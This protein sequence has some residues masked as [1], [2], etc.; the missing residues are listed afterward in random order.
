MAGIHYISIPTIDN[1]NLPNEI[2]DKCYK[3]YERYGKYKIYDILNE[4][5]N[6]SRYSYAIRNKFKNINLIKRY[7]YLYRQAMVQT[8]SFVYN[9]EEFELIDPD[10]YAGDN[11]VCPKCGKELKV[12]PQRGSETYYPL[13]HYRDIQEIVDK[14]VTYKRFPVK[15]TLYITFDEFVSSKEAA[16][17]TDF[18]FMYWSVNKDGTP[19][20]IS[21]I[22]TRYLNEDGDL[23]LYAC[24]ASSATISETS[25]TLVSTKIVKIVRYNFRVYFRDF[26]NCKTEK[27]TKTG[28]VFSNWTLDDGSE[29]PVDLTEEQLDM[30][31]TE[32][33]NVDGYVDVVDIFT[34]DPE[35]SDYILEY[36]A[37]IRDFEKLFKVEE[38]E[39]Y[40][41]KGF[42]YNQY[43]KSMGGIEVHDLEVVASQTK[44][45]S[46]IVYEMTQD[47]SLIPWR[48]LDR[49]KYKFSHYTLN[50]DGSEMTPSQE[51]TSIAAGTHLQMYAVFKDIYDEDCKVLDMQNMY[52]DIWGENKVILYAQYS[53]DI[54]E[55][56]Y[57]YDDSVY[58]CQKSNFIYR[59]ETSLTSPEDRTS[60]QT[61]IN[62]YLTE[63]YGNEVTYPTMKNETFHGWSL[64]N[65]GE[66][67]TNFGVKYNE[68]ET[69]TLY[70][71]FNHANKHWGIDRFNR[72]TKNCYCP[73]CRKRN[74]YLGRYSEA[75]HDYVKD[76]YL[77][78]L[79]YTYFN[80]ELG[81]HKRYVNGNNE[82]TYGTIPEI[83]SVSTLEDLNKSS[84]I[85]NG[86]TCVD[87]SRYA[88][89][90]NSSYKIY[91]YD[92]SRD[93]NYNPN[94]III[95]DDEPDMLDKKWIYLPRDRIVLTP[96]D[97]TG[98]GKL[99]YILSGF[100]K[101]Y[102]KQDGEII[103]VSEKNNKPLEITLQALAN[104]F[105]VNSSVEVVIGKNSDNTAYS[106]KYSV[107]LS[108][109]SINN[110][111][112]YNDEE[113]D[114]FSFTVE[115]PLVFTPTTSTFEGLYPNNVTTWK[116]S[117]IVG[118]YIV[119]GGYP[120][121]ESA[122]NILNIDPNSKIIDENGEEHIVTYYDT[123]RYKLSPIVEVG[124][125]R[126]T[127]TP[128]GRSLQAGGN[129]VANYTTLNSGETVDNNSYYVDADGNVITDLSAY[130]G[131]NY[132]GWH[133]IR[134]D[135]TKHYSIQDG[136]EYWLV[137]PNN[138][139]VTLRE[140]INTEEE[141]PITINGQRYNFTCYSIDGYAPITDKILDSTTILAKGKYKIHKVYTSTAIVV[142][143]GIVESSLF[144]TKIDDI[145]KG[146][147][148]RIL[149]IA[150]FNSTG[151][152]IRYCDNDTC[153]S[154]FRDIYQRKWSFHN[155]NA[156]VKNTATGMSTSNFSLDD[157]DFTPT[158][159]K[160]KS[161]LWRYPQTNQNKSVMFHRGG[162]GDIDKY[163]FDFEYKYATDEYNA[164]K[165]A[166]PSLSSSNNEYKSYVLKNLLKRIKG[167]DIVP[168]QDRPLKLYQ[169]Q[170]KEKLFQRF[171]EIYALMIEYT[172][173]HLLNKDEVE[174]MNDILQ[175]LPYDFRLG[176][177]SFLNTWDHYIK[178]SVSE[179]ADEN[180]ETYVDRIK[181]NFSVFFESN[182]LVVKNTI[183]YKKALF[184]EKVL[185]PLFNSLRNV[186][187][188][189]ES[190]Y[191]AHPVSVPVSK[192]HFGTITET[193]SMESVYNY[194]VENY[195]P[196]RLADLSPEKYVFIRWSLTEDGEP[197][198]YSDLNQFVRIG[199]DD[200]PTQVQFYAYFKE[201]YVDIV[202]ERNI[203]E[204]WFKDKDTFLNLYYSDEDL[205]SETHTLFSDIAK[206][207][208][209]GVDKTWWSRTYNNS[210]E[211]TYTIDD[212]IAS[213]TDV[214]FVNQFKDLV[215][216]VSE[217]IE[218]ETGVT[219]NM[220]LD[221][222]LASLENR[223]DNTD[224]D[225]LVFSHWS[226]D[227]YSTIP[228]EVRTDIKRIYSSYTT[229]KIYKVS[230]LRH[231]VD[232]STFSKDWFNGKEYTLAYIKDSLANYHEKLCMPMTFVSYMFGIMIWP[233]RI[234]AMTDSNGEIGSYVL[235][236]DT[237]VTSN[238]ID[239]KT[240]M[241]RKSSNGNS[242]L[243][244]K[245]SVVSKRFPAI[246]DTY[247]GNKIYEQYYIVSES[248]GTSFKVYSFM[249]NA[250]VD[251]Y[252][253][254]SDAYDYCLLLKNTSNP[255]L[256]YNPSRLVDIIAYSSN[257]D[258]S[259]LCII[260]DTCIVLFNC[261]TN[262]WITSFPPSSLFTKPN[263]FI[264][265]CTYN[266]EK[267]VIYLLSSQNEIATFDLNDESI[268][269]S[270]RTPNRDYD[271]VHIFF[272]PS[273]V[274]LT[275]SNIDTNVP[276]DINLLAA[277]VVNDESEETD[278]SAILVKQIANIEPYILPENEK[279]WILKSEYSETP[280]LPRGI[281]DKYYEE[282]SI[283]NQE[284]Y[285][286]NE[287]LTLRYSYEMLG[288]I[289]PEQTIEFS[290]NN[291]IYKRLSF[292]NNGISITDYQLNKR[293]LNSIGIYAV[294]YKEGVTVS[295]KQGYFISKTETKI[296]KDVFLNDLEHNQHQGT[297]DSSTGA[298]DDYELPTHIDK[299]YSLEGFDI[300][301]V[302]DP[303]LAIVDNT[304]IK[305]ARFTNGRFK[306][307]SAVDYSDGNPVMT[308]TGADTGRKVYI[309]YKN[310]KITVLSTH[311]YTPSIFK[312][313][314]TTGEE[315][316]VIGTTD[317]IKN[318]FINYY[319]NKKK[320]HCVKLG[321]E[322]L[323]DES[324]Y[325][326]QLD[327][328]RYIDGTPT[329]YLDAKIDQA[330]FD[331]Y[332]T[333]HL[334]YNIFDGENT[335]ISRIN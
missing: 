80:G 66:E 217:E 197:L 134:D 182:K 107:V 86:T 147:F 46:T 75:T 68:G 21:E 24:Y 241:H 114:N 31:I 166:H 132:S 151:N 127:V 45:L 16:E 201:V 206:R 285:T 286:V 324:F 138:Y 145:I 122:K 56:T 65:N 228:D 265:G 32:L 17:L 196:Y 302:Y 232:V 146:G 195:D 173:Y 123:D 25:Q 74:S 19:C 287:K 35:T 88:D 57:C 179:W 100:V 156:T 294:Y 105:D 245:F 305:I 48:Y 97:T 301:D 177:I 43:D 207:Y 54:P 116:D 194:V 208:E 79:R 2:I 155:Q 231:E 292:Y 310:Q 335:D 7:L 93:K 311:E 291:Y 276:L 140:L 268:W 9:T 121:A 277:T 153:Y 168:I 248:I 216:Y 101:V 271:S 33:M 11:T 133:W 118:N 322:S 247:T 209:P 267:N 10:L 281:S 3:A 164:K 8:M 150:G 239:S 50:S 306:I 81:W 92:N 240:M 112:E 225:D 243:N 230:R 125:E 221:A 99:K 62:N 242:T 158:V 303:V 1:C 258:V 246:V 87:T 139:P 282:L 274:D 36:D 188:N 236:S 297:I 40:I 319:T 299:I 327:V 115:T 136:E 185:T 95:D 260:Y 78:I 130:N 255:A 293:L 298:V 108:G 49:E 251:E 262:T 90:S 318:L 190:C 18:K 181:K 102:M 214:E 283:E 307:L 53:Y 117:D 61:M 29:V 316:T 183:Y 320:L 77:D 309:V 161:E 235:S 289:I 103:R 85:P 84:L 180:F 222:V 284:K 69:V 266:K 20:D 63:T 256:V 203:D 119:D 89:A 296:R 172:P 5:M 142:G 253:L 252:F 211:D 270:D 152:L 106:V 47:E 113:K 13:S 215:N 189:E 290:G 44:R 334:K 313:A 249:R 212:F 238:D 227:G 332:V 213:F 205:L 259:N 109:Y 187:L 159:Y 250:W 321:N 28:Y 272:T 223:G 234:A 226:L 220:T 144:D 4:E 304:R 38:K 315:I 202:A 126:V 233:K 70:A 174:V 12:L 314:S 330:D 312:N 15:D 331:F 76:G 39:N 58:S 275:T 82:T 34:G 257:N 157:Y 325:G 192:N 210:D 323:A 244:I 169:D 254:G 165:Y 154:K 72:Y 329:T 98:N 23:I 186:L 176:I 37:T 110:D 273:E 42:T 224:T 333:K 279:T 199:E 193:T 288:N 27:P 200:D 184:Y 263:A 261:Y 64:S 191:I 278:N 94:D 300:D 148:K 163:R 128:R 237:M 59:F 51:N 120:T 317:N 204:S 104:T 111:T 141:D 219:E 175:G 308:I 96:I 26:I 131:L 135:L 198:S 124:V 326:R 91:I 328:S 171:N 73:I 30:D 52:I 6:S 178:Y 264:K 280:I 295:E 137:N 41:F 60:L 170:Y 14:V 143:V 269:K 167:T 67:I 55:G 218:F 83:A 71:I 22:V 129:N 229:V 149:F 162:S 160:T